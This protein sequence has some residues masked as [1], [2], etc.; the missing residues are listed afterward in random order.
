MLRVLKVH[1]CLCLDV[2]VLKSSD[3][4]TT[5]KDGLPGIHEQH[6]DTERAGGGLV[7]DGDDSIL[8]L[9]LVSWSPLHGYYVATPL[10]RG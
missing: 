9:I 4:P 10:R 7:H 6:Q 5:K 3:F 1:C 8:R 2:P